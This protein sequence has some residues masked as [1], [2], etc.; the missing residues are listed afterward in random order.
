MDDRQQ[1][2]LTVVYDSGMDE[3]VTETL[4]DLDVPG[5]TKM[6]S[7][8]GFG[9]AGRKEGSPVFPGTVNVLYL[10][11]DAPDVERVAA[12]LRALQQSYRRNPGLTIWTQPAALLAKPAGSR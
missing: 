9:G 2:L 11:L 10:A 5:W 12:A 6:F 1:I 7:G 4:T 8:H 3:R